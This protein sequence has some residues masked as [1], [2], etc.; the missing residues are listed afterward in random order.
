MRWKRPSLQAVPAL[1]RVLSQKSKKKAPVWKMYAFGIQLTL[2]TMSVPEKLRVMEALWDD[3]SR[4]SK[5]FQSP[6]W[7][8]AALKERK[9]R[10]ASGRTSYMDWE[11]AKKEIRRRVA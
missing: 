8:Q 6:R 3:L 7:H 4:N 11:R 5:P 1:L 2:S 9:K 10:I